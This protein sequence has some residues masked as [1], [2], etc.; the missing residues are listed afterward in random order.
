[1]A[2][3]LTLLGLSAHGAIRSAARLDAM[4]RLLAIVLL[5]LL[6]LQAS[7]AAVASYCAHEAQAGAT[8]LGHH[9]HRHRADAGQSAEADHAVHS[10]ADEHG[11]KTPGANDLDCGQCHGGCSAMITMP[12][13]LPG[14][15]SA[16]VPLPTVDEDGGAHAPNR[17]ERP[18]WRRLA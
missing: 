2:T 1:M 16:A 11:S 15:V 13:A 18:Q 12:V 9:E 7:W 17:P 5:A 10:P 8:H 3:W 6:P 4:S 14:L